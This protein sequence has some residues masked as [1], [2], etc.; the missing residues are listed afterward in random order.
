MAQGNASPANRRVGAGVLGGIAVLLSAIGTGYWLTR[1]QESPPETSRPQDSRRREDVSPSKPEPA[2]RPVPSV[3]TSKQ[4]K[5]GQP[6]P[7]PPD[8]R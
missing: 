6:K 7:P 4:E 5:T 3:S 2:K 8:I 1:E